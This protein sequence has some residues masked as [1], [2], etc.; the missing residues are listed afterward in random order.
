MEMSQIHLSEK[1][2]NQNMKPKTLV[3]EFSQKEKNSGE[4]IKF[5][6]GI[7]NNYIKMMIREGI[8]IYLCQL[9]LNQL[10]T[11]NKYFRSFDTIEEAY[12]DL[13]LI[14]STNKYE[15]KAEDN[16]IT[17][18]VEIEY[19]YKKYIVPF[20]LEKLGAKKEEKK[21]SEYMTDNYNTNNNIDNSL[22]KELNNKVN[23]L[24]EKLNSFEDKINLIYEYIND[25]KIKKE[26]EDDE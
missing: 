4:K 17:I 19:S 25:K 1:T 14:F 16:T 26:K 5:I 8:D 12:N 22:L 11:Q 21:E 10:S 23:K 7:Q 3:N 6:F 2:N 9:N 24:E 18:S 15:I 13:L 20:V